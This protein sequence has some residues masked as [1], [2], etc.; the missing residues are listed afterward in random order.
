MSTNEDK[1]KREFEN[2]LRVRGDSV[3]EKFLGPYKDVVEDIV[4]VDR[5]KDETS[6]ETYLNALKKAASEAEKQDIF[7]KSQ[8]FQETSF[9]IKDLTSLSNL[10]DAVDILLNNSEYKNLIE[11]HIQRVSLIS[12]AIDLRHQYI[13]EYQKNR[14]KQYVNDIVMSIQKELQVR[15]SNT[16]IPDIDLHTILLNKYK[17]ERFNDI[18]QMIKRERMIEERNVYSYRVVAKAVPYTG[19]VELQ[20]VSKSKTVFSDAFKEYDNAYNFLQ[21]LK[22]KESIPSSEYY[23]YFVNINYEVLNQY[24]T[25]ASGG[26]RSEYNLLQELTDASRCEILILDEPESSFD[27]L[28]LKDG[29]NTLLKEVSKQIPVIIATHNNTIGASVHPDY[30]IYTCKEIQEDGTP[31]YHLYSGNPSSSE[32]KNLDGDTISR[33]EVVLDCLEAGEPA[34][35]DRRTSYEILNN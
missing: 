1:D 19:A 28:F 17:V 6:V 4:S 31:K 8:L 9:G 30:L 7:A 34:Y 18:S 13:M 26:E 22:K 32:L 11:H 10:V 16:P 21:I 33:R 12:L 5:V 20:R 2:M 29:V 25:Q 23:K 24:G 15:S 27:N 35:M 14:Q 3:T